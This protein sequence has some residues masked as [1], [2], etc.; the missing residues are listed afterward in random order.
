VF[1]S[2]K[3]NIKRFYHELQKMYRHIMVENPTYTTPDETDLRGS[4]K[5][6]LKHPVSYSRFL[7]YLN[8]SAESLL[9][10][11]FTDPEIFKFFDKLTSTYCYTTV[12]E[13]P[14]VLASVMFVDNHVGG[15]YYPAGSTLFLPGKMEKV[16][17]ENGGDMMYQS[18]VT[19]IIFDQSR[20]IGVDL[21]QSYRF[22]C[23]F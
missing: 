19:G 2:E 3:N 16:I 9:K 5:S 4:L 7:S 22:S 21:T 23:T 17:E 13:S 1:P 6:L 8:K 15:S 11:Y 18:E 20:A 14:A 12:K 10:K